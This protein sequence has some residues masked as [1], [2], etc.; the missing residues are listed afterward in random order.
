MLSY[1]STLRPFSCYVIPVLV[2]AERKFVRY[3]CMKTYFIEINTTHVHVIT[4]TSLLIYCRCRSKW[5]KHSADW[6]IFEVKVPKTYSYILGMMEEILHRRLTDTL[7]LYCA[8]D[9]HPNDPRRIRERLAPFPPPP[10]EDLKARR[11]SRFS[12]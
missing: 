11:R 10:M 4:M 9:P 5:S 3:L 7:P 8:A 1:M 2:L 12:T 6:V